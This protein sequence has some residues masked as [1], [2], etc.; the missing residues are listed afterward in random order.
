[1]IQKHTLSLCCVFHGIR[2]KVNKGWVVVMTTLLFLCQYKVLP[3]VC[4]S[5][6]LIEEATLCA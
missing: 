5:Y 4:L 2:F 1:M 3:R 6:L